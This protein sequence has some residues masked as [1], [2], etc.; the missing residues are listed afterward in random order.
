MASIISELYRGALH[1]H[2]HDF[3]YISEYA[4]LA[5]DYKKDELWL[6]EHL[7]G[8]EREKAAELADI[9]GAMS[10]IA[11]YECFR[12]GFILGASLVM[13]VSVELDRRLRSENSGH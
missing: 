2:E 6:R 1:P 10:G 3:S 4:D 7:E 8:E 9:C 12:E 11:S 5:N 13:E